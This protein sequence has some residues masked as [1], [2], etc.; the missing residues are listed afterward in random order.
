MSRITNDREL[1]ERVKAAFELGISLKRFDGWEPRTFYVHEAGV[2]VSS[3][4]ES[5][6]DAQER[7]WMLAYAAYLENCCARCGGDLHE[8]T[9]PANEDGYVHLLP[10]QCA[11]CVE[12]E[13]ATKEYEREP[14]A[15]TLMHRVKLK[16]EVARHG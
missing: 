14:F 16:R 4:P 1:R 2:L 8:T 3:I 9:N 5:E 10:V 11:R 13:R 6:W 15:Q 7:G 12:F